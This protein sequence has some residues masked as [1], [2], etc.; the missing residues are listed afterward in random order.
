[1]RTQVDDRNSSMPERIANAMYGLMASLTTRAALRADGGLAPMDPATEQQLQR[2]G[3][4]LVAALV[5]TVFALMPQLALAD[6]GGFL[7]DNTEGFRTDV[8]GSW[9]L[10]S[11]VVIFLGL[12]VLVIGLFVPMAS[13]L[14]GGAIA[15]VGVGAFG[16]SVVT[17]LYEIG[18]N[19]AGTTGG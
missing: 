6:G 15:A 3:N 2:M 4:F 7:P 10:I 9:T 1:M 13:W 17:W 14:K 19:S 8:K 5:L 11:Y 12:A 16:E 18:G